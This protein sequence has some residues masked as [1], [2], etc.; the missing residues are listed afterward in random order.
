MTTD[1]IRIRRCP[2]RVGILDTHI[3]R[4]LT[5]PSR[6][7]VHQGPTGQCLGGYACEGAVPHVRGSCEPVPEVIPIGKCPNKY[8]VNFLIHFVGMPFWFFLLKISVFVLAFF[9]LYSFSKVIVETS[10]HL[11]QFFL[12]SGKFLYSYNIFNALE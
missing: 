5:A 11:Y 12:Y 1:Q 9:L 2:I 10:N 6:R 7:A 3:A 4:R 8:R